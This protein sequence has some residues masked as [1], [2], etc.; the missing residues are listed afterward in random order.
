M[1]LHDAGA[2]DG[3]VDFRLFHGEVER[4][5]DAVEK[6]GE[7]ICFTAGKNSSPA[8]PRV[9]VRVEIAVDALSISIKRI[10]DA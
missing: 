6:H 3:E 5:V 9:T 1:D 7:L 10:D 4:I 8:Q 2:T